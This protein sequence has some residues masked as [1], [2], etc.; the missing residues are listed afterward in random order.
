MVGGKLAPATH[1]QRH[2]PRGYAP[3]MPS[4]RVADP[5]ADPRMRGVLLDGH[6]STTGATSLGDLPAEVARRR[7][8]RRSSSGCNPAKCAV[9]EACPTQR[10][11]GWW[12]RRGNQ[13]PLSQYRPLSHRKIRKTRWHRPA[14]GRHCPRTLVGAA[15]CATGFQRQAPTV[16]SYRKLWSVRSSDAD[17]A[18]WIADRD[19]CRAQGY[20]MRPS[21]RP[22]RGR[23]CSNACWRRRCRSRGS[24]P[25]KPTVRPAI[26]ATDR[27]SGQSLCGGHV[28][29]TG[30]DGH[31]GLGPPFDRTA[32]G[33]AIM[34]RQTTATL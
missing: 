9:S 7:A 12:R 29:R 20:R 15:T 33:A 1:A 3:T 28:D 27:R 10:S 16:T 18:S 31:I 14:T 23:R 17:R 19:R 4:A 26:C 30:L 13:P 5:A 25:T 34:L 24:P 8:V 2:V 32:H 21:S 6:M 22:R 11:A